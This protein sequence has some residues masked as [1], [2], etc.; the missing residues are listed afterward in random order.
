[1][2][3]VFCFI[4]ALTVGMAVKAT[5]VTSI[6]SV[7]EFQNFAASVN[8]GDNYN[9]VSVYLNADIDLNN[10][11]WTPI[12]TSEHP[13]RGHFEGGDHKISNLTVNT[14][15]LYAGLFGYVDK[16][17]EVKEVHIL[18]GTIAVAT[19]P[20]VNASYHGG[21]A[22]YNL[23]AINKCSNRATVSG[24]NYVH[25]RI[26]GIVG[27]NGTDQGYSGVVRNCYNLGDVY[28]SLTNVYIGGIV[29]YNY[30]SVY[31]SFMRSDVIKGDPNS[32]SS[33]SNY[34]LYG[35]NGGTVT[36]C[37]YAGG[38]T[39][40]VSAPI[41]L[42]DDSDNSSTLTTNDGQTKNIL[43]SS[44]T[45]FTDGDWNTLCLP[46]SIPQGPNGFFPIAGATVMKLSSSSFSD[47]VLTLSF[48]YA[49]SIEAG[50]PYIV[51]WNTDL[52]NIS[53]PVFMG[54]T[55]SNSTTTT[56]TECVDFVGSFSP[57][58]L[59]ANDNTKLYLGSSNKLY[60]PS[61]EKVI[62][63]CRAHF[64]LKDGLTAGDPDPSAGIK[65]FVLNFGNGDET[66]GISLTPSSP[67]LSQGEGSSYWYALDGRRFNAKPT[68]RGIYIHNGKKEVIR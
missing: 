14:S 42:A 13:F 26:G 36:G 57:V 52:G 64:Q 48:D 2:R 20:G 44:R 32:S 41:V 5:V 56:I 65:A 50:K 4:L 46:F 3:K 29:G 6:G 38:A 53:N 43:F 39:T 23:G 27:E 58:T 34:P 9:N 60:Y 68:E 40:D 16:G 55:V 7:T 22:G 30:G 59:A 17:A 67:G 49:F 24:S 21:I 8:A 11:A 63:A 35:N 33:H 54:V 15:G 25:A 1:M 28:S 10:E 47:G 19:D 51:K 37:F 62:K 45:L 31:N 61:K 18:S 12:G 66:T